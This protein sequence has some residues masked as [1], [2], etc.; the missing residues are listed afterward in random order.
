[1]ILNVKS[2]AAYLFM[3]W[4][5]SFIDV[6]YYLINHTTK[7]TNPSC[8]KTIGPITTKSKILWHV[9][10][11][12]ADSEA[13]GLFVDYQQIVPIWISLIGLD[14]LQPKTLLKTYNFTSKGYSNWSIRQKWSKSW[15]M[16]FSWLRERDAQEQL[17]LSGTKVSITIKIISQIATHPPVIDACAQNWYKKCKQCVN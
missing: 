3:P 14:H 2:Y 4:D 6:H 10:I 15:D 9:I 13:G 7:P 16:R 1:M 17:K 8:V 11:S 5:C 12:A